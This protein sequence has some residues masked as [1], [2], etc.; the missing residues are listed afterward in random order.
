M[1]TKKK[2]MLT[3]SPERKKHFSRLLKRMFNKGE[4]KAAKRLSRRIMVM[5]ER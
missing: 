2:G 5:G 3:V 4:R 1:A